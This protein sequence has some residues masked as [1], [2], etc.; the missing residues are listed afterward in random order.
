[1]MCCFNHEDDPTCQPILN[2]FEVGF[3]FSVWHDN[4]FLLLR[5]NESMVGLLG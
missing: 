2:G 1:M 5:W 3:S 4:G